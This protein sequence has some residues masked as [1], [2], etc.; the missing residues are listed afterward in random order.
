I[1]DQAD[2]FAWEYMS[3]GLIGAHPWSGEYVFPTHRPVYATWYALRRYVL[4]RL[5]AFINASELPV[6]EPA[7]KNDIGKFDAALGALTQGNN[8]VHS[9]GG[10]IWLYP[11]AA[12]LDDKR[13][14]SRTSAD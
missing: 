12:Q 4:P 7:E 5:F 11:A 8:R 6:I 14:A 3:D 2:Y 1:V 9:H 10:I 13:M